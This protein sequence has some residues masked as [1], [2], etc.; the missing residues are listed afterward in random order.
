ML[1]NKERCRILLVSHGWPLEKYGGV[2]LYVQMLV[3]E[4]FEMGHLVFLLTPAEST[5][6]VIHKT[7][8]KWGTHI[9]LEQPPISR[10]SQT[11]KWPQRDN[12]IENIVRDIDPDIIHLHHLDRLG[13]CVWEQRLRDITIL[14]TLH[15]YASICSRGQLYD[16][17]R[18]M[19]CNG[20]CI[21]E[22]ATCLQFELHH[23]PITNF[24]QKWFPLNS[25][26]LKSLSTQIPNI[27]ILHRIRMYQ[28]ISQSRRLLHNVFTISPSL[29]LQRRFVERGF[30][31]AFYLELPLLRDLPKE[32]ASKSSKGFLFAGSLIESKGLNLLLKAFEPFIDHRLTIAGSGPL[33]KRQHAYPQYNWLGHVNHNEMLKIM[34]EHHTIILPSL[35]PENAPISLREAAALGLQII[36]TSG[37]GE[38]ISKHSIVVDRTIEGLRDGIQLAINKRKKQA[39]QIAPKMLHRRQHCEQLISYYDFCLEQNSLKN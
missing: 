11:W 35:W 20:P 33:Q 38:E 14:Y 19:I 30:T 39:T 17:H 2:G 25:E 23:N 16:P 29:N 7:N 34:A 15:D 9:S 32:N 24:I 28:R 36:C 8:Y 37:G 31:N 22:C 27:S 6:F 21:Y 10:Y 26:E 18:N 13:L 5:K 12:Y 3:R 1:K 4:F